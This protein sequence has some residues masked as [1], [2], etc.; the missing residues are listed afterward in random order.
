MNTARS[1]ALAASVALTLTLV[2]TACGPAE[3]TKPNNAPN[4]PGGAYSVA[5]TEPDHLLPGRT[6]SSYSL[7]VLQG[8]F[9]PPASLDPKNGTVKPLAALSWLTEDN[10]VWTITFRSGT[11]F[12]NGEKVTAASYAD[13][14][15]AAAYGPNGWDSNYYFAQIKGYDALNPTE[16]GA[17]PT[18]RTLSGLKV[19]DETTLQ[20]T[21]K[22]PFGQFPMLLS[23]PAFAPSPR[24]PSP[25]RTPSTSRRSATAPTSSTAS[26]SATRRSS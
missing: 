11:T 6:T 22:A 1:T 19:V 12:H 9:D 8:L 26:G 2:G 21:L 4:K 24:R 7:Q 16:E 5:L 18:A 13:A 10:V 15:N 23:F 17:K 25:S 14:W 3:S 20:V